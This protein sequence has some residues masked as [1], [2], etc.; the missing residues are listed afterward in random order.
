MELL[1]NLIDCGMEISTRGRA[2]QTPRTQNG[3][4]SYSHY[5]AAD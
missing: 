2:A 1:K 4:V 5:S 3:H